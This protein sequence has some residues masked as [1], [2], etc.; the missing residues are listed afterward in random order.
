[1]LAYQRLAF[2]DL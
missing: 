2:A 1:M